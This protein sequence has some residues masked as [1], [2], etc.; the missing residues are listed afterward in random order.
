LFNVKRS[1]AAIIALG[2]YLR[3]LSG[4]T[5]T[6]TPEP[7]LLLTNIAQVRALSDDEALR[8]YAV[9]LT[10][11]VTFEISLRYFFIHDLTNGLCVERTNATFH[12]KPGQ[13]VELEGATHRPES[14]GPLLTAERVKV[15]GEGQLPAPRQ[16]PFDGLGS[17]QEDCQLLEVRGIVRTA[18]QTAEDRFDVELA[19]AGRKLRVYL[20]A[21]PAGCESRLVDSTVVARG[22]R[23]CIFNQK[24]QVLAPLLFVDTNNFRI[25]EFAPEDAFAGAARPLS[26]LLQFTPNPHYGHRT[27]VRG[28]VTY[29]QPGRSVFITDRTQGLRLQTVQ[30]NRLEPGDIIEAMGFEAI[31]KLSPVLE[32]VVY[33]PVGHESP[34][35]PAKTTVT[36]ALGGA[37][38]A[39]L[40]AIEGTLVGS[41][42]RGTEEVLIMQE[43]GVA[44]DAQLSQAAAQFQDARL[45]LEGSRLQLTGICQVQDIIEEEST[46][47]PET[48][49]IL[50][51]SPAD[52]AVLQ[53]PPWWNPKRMAWLLSGVTV[54]FLA[55]LGG[56]IARS[57]LKLREQGRERME[58]EGR[59]SAIMAERNRMAREIHDTLAQGY[60]AISAQL[61]ILKDKVAGSPQA[62][63]PLEL[64]RGMV[65]SSLAEARRSIWEMRSQAL[66]EAELHQALA[67][68]AEQLTTGTPVRVSVSTQGAPR[69]LPIIV[70]NNLLRI[71]QEAITNALKYAHPK[72]IC[73]ALEYEAKAV[74][75]CVRD[76]G[77]GFD[78]S[79]VV[80]SKSG[81]FGLVG[82]KERVQQMSGQFAVRSQPG[83]GTEVLVEV[84]VA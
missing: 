71:G 30:T 23:G 31:E 34:P 8:G 20:P 69:R 52:I 21:L 24:R 18:V 27:K 75:L 61:E 67:N 35:K 39:D 58:T 33:R 37:H 53:K 32:D 62:T 5:Q 15:I 78:P 42:L 54:L 38:D 77:C 56:V 19:V 79:G 60:T 28:V 82:M 11:V 10:G 59:F 3:A 65:R 9:R 14:N 1:F 66:E 22:V 68:V 13:M 80:A 84:P 2:W 12:L 29:Q 73:I 17:I 45:L 25:Q 48:F 55:A 6:V 74:R 51:R 63:K 16:V 36:E 7:A 64:A 41:V 72:E 26:S 76:D 46:V 81:G 49:R 83:Q 70:E 57:K 44:F 40:V 47:R 43:N 50:V 4:P